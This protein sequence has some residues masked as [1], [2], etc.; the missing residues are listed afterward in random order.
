[1]SFFRAKHTHINTAHPVAAPYHTAVLAKNVAAFAAG[2]PKMVSAAKCSTTAI[3][4]AIMVNFAA[5][6]PGADLR[7]GVSTTF[8]GP[9]ICPLGMFIFCSLSESILNYPVMA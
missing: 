5:L 6:L 8:I 3:T 7:I 4:A 2:S 9:F 1:V